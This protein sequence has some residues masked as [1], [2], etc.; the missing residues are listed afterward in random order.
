MTEHRAGRVVAGV[1]DTPEGRAAVH[2]AAEIAETFSRPLHLVRVWRDVDWFLSAPRTAMPA[3]RRDKLHDG[4]L[5]DEA[6]RTAR[7]VAPSVPVTA[8]M[9]PG[10]IYAVLLEQS[11]DAHTLV[12]GSE[13]DDSVGTI[14]RWYLDHARCPVLVVDAAGE[15]VAG[16]VRPHADP[17][18][19]AR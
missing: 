15:A 5:L 1:A 2:T 18:G 8:E 9:T 10:S 7:Q 17:A 6:L 14:A 3:L 19:A 13:R 4:E 16:T 11:R 12:L